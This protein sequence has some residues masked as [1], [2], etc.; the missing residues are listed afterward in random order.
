MPPSIRARPRPATMIECDPAVARAR[1][2]AQFSS[3]N[4]RSS[5][6]GI[7]PTPG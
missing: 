7:V 5:G 2:P 1:A 3:P 4:G 6:P